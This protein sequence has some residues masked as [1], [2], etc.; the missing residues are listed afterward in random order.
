MKTPTRAWLSLMGLLAA[1]CVPAHA[2]V[3]ILSFRPTLKPPQTI[4]TSI[5]WTVTATDTNPGP[6][7]FKF[8]I[9]A[10]NAT[11]FTLLMDFN[12]GTLNAG[13]WTSPPFLWVPTGIEGTYKIQFIAKD[14]TS[15]E[16]AASQISFQ[17][18]PLV[19]GSTP[20]V[21]PTSNPLMA[22]FSAPSCAAGSAMRVSFSTTAQKLAPAF[23][24][25]W[26]NCHPPNTMTFEIAGMYQNTTYQMYSQT[27]TGGK[28]V[29]G[30]PVSFTTG[31]LPASIPF[32]PFQ[33]E[34]P[35]GSHTYTADSVLLV[36]SFNFGTGYN[37]PEVAT[38][39]SG[40]VIWFYYPRD[41]NNVELLTRP[42]QGG[43]SLTIQSDS[44]WNPASQKEQF[45]R[46]LDLLGNVIR[47]TNTGALQQEL[48]AMGAT[49]AQ[50]CNSISN[51][52]IG[53]AC[54]GSF[55]HD[56]IQSLPN[57]STAVIADIEKIF[58][59]GTQG[60]TTGLPVDIIGDMI[61]VLN[62][63][64]QVSWYWDAFDHVTGC[65]APPNTGPCQLDI[66]RPAVLGE[67]CTAN[68]PGCPPVFL[69]GPGIAPLAKDWLHANS[70]YYWPNDTFGGASGDIV[71]SSRHQDWVMK[72]DYNNGSQTGGLGTG[73]ILWRMGPDGDFYFNNNYGDPWP[74]FSHQHEIGIENNGAG[75]MTLFDNGNTRVSP[76]PL[77]LGPGCQPS[78]CDSRGMALTFDETGMTVTP[79]LSV[80]LGVYSMAMGSAQLLPNGN[81]FFLAAIVV[82]SQNDV[83]SYSIEIL[84]AAGTDT[85]TQVLNL[86]SPEAYRAWRMP[87]LYNPPTT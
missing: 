17:V 49:D 62:A 47:E 27:V 16:S 55:H 35:P 73:N 25:N 22:L 83:A 87:S 59:A 14:F 26:V 65:P 20:V 52:T 31:S 56:A 12:L 79:Q 63:N 68:Q 74:W 66:N 57:G 24:T 80:D 39:L 13:T 5:T 36:N 53:S 45:L 61:I 19:T 4:G 34:V 50:P 21:V 64:W 42:L 48:L 67:T 54:L 32:P 60:D 3:Q 37:Y 6:L 76:P 86:R 15:G 28:I 10:P 82:V 44:A 71:W 40:N 85:G 46:Q 78:D 41:S 8:N 77:G 43:N 69:L 33:V 18:N 11:S 81:Y 72:I 58:P 2:T 84:P 1:P 23:T 75:P 9:A 38:D 7:A 30:T 51:P 29:N 70:L